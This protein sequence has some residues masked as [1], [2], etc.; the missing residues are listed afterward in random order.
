MIKLFSFT[1]TMPG[2]GTLNIDVIDYDNAF[3]HDLIGKAVID[4]ES[5]YFDL[6]W[7][8]LVEKPIERLPIYHDEYSVQQGEITLWIDIFDRKDSYKRNNPVFIKGRPPSKMEVRLV[9]WECEGI[10][11]M[12]MESSDIFF[13]ATI[14]QES[15]ATD[16]HFNCWQ[17]AG[18][19][20]WRIIIPI[21]YEERKNKEIF[22][23]LQAYDY[24][25]FSKNDF[26]AQ[27]SFSIAKLLKECDK[28]DVPIK[29]D[30]TYFEHSF[31]RGYQNME[32]MYD[33]F[34]FEDDEKF[35]VR[36]DR[37]MA[38]KFKVKKF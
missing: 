29:F 6:N 21:E 15:Q 19:F 11:N 7:N 4:I 26:I 9:I 17:G 3:S 33:M 37:G 35:W 5:R 12:D 16:V 23:N 38:R 8:S 1:A 28:Y 22:I 2:S 20:N 31:K 34:E 27:K 25:I 36:L 14:G 10:K 13:N 24:D 32:T 30:K 18:S